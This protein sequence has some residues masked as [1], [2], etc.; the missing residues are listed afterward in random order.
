MNATADASTTFQYSLSHIRKHG[1]GMLQLILLF[2]WATAVPMFG[3]VGRLWAEAAGAEFHT[4]PIWFLSVHGP[5]L[6]LWGY[7]LDR[8]PELSRWGFRATAAGNLVLTA[9]LLAAPPAAWTLIFGLMGFT[10]ALG[11]VSWGRWYATAVDPAW[12][13]RTFALSATGVSIINAL[14]NLASRWFSPGSALLLALV[15]LA[16]LLFVPP[17]RPAESRDR[18]EPESASGPPERWGSFARLAAFILWYSLVAGLS[19]R[20]LVHTPISPIIDDALRRLPYM[21]GVLT[22][23]LIA[24]RRNLQSVMIPGAGLL[25]LSFLIGVWN[26]QS[27]LVHVSVGLN[28]LAFGLLESSPWLLLASSIRSGN[29]GRWFGWGLNLN[30]V[31][32]LFGALVP[33]P[34]DGMSPER[35]GLLASICI[36]LGILSLTG[37]ADPLSAIHESPRNAA[38]LPR[39]ELESEERLLEKHF[40]EKLSPRELEVGML[41][42][43]GLSTREIAEQTHLSENTIKTHLRGL[44]RKT[45]SANRND[46]YRKLVERG[47]RESDTDHA[48]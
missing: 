21:C 40:G 8:Y 6:V 11:M 14:F 47:I 38:P 27:F 5:S 24:D 48:G 2:G 34:L 9:S 28:G 31:P 15:P 41:A 7:A 29:A 23:G 42:I 43:Q 46:L 32:I 18:P 37:V 33:L 12:L 3:T 22:A 16:A 10:T 20:F 4:L 36:V 25:A 13:G 17:A 1:L 39:M 45:E 19:Y 44:F 26:Q 35:L 30:V